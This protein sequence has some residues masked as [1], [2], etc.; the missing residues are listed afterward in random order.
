MNKNILYAAGLLLVSCQHE[1][2]FPVRPVVS[3]PT[4]KLVAAVVIT[5]PAQTDYDSIV[6]RYAAD[7]IREVHIDPFKDSSTRTYYFDAG[8]RLSALEDEKAIYYTNNDA[9]K[10]ISF[11]YD[12]NGQL[13]KTLTDFKTVSGV[14]AFY[15]AMNSSNGKK[16]IVFDT[17]YSGNAYTLEWN[18]HIVWSTI[19]NSNRLVYDSGIFVNPFD[20]S[21]FKTFVNEYS[22]GSD[23]SITSINKRVY[24]N[25][26]LAEYGTVNA[27]SAKIAP[28]YR[29]LHKKLYRNLSNWF[30]ISLAWQ[31]DNYHI[32]PLAGGP[33]TSI[34]YNGH[35]TTSGTAPYT[36]NY[37]FDNS[38]SGDQLDRSLVNYAL[39]G[40]GTSKYTTVIRFYYKQ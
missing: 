4:E 5:N 9:A 14:P 38:Y 22:Y 33:Y 24:F 1:L 16:I 39:L 30:D 32:F 40:Q 6:F 31:D 20:K 23:S 37:E 25:A 12:A 21:L 26:Q 18:N 2:R 11:Q 34:L 10:R 35:S 15:N 13:E 3:V 19:D 28:V 7:K 36:R 8:G 29:A 27:S 17:A